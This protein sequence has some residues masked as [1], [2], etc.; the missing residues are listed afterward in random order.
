MAILQL[1]APSVLTTYI[2]KGYENLMNVLWKFLC[3]ILTFFPWF[4]SWWPFHSGMASE[5]QR[6]G[7]VPPIP[8]TRA[9]R[10]PGEE[11]NTHRDK[12]VKLYI[13]EE[14]SQKEI[15]DIMTKEHNFIIT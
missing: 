1:V 3:N 15:I 2:Q 5:Y 4:L 6:P 9:R 10:I 7:A 8:S 11:W 12:L 14:A 13:E